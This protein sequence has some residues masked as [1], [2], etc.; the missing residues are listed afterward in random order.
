MEDE[1]GG[2]SD[3]T[4]LHRWVFR[5]RG[6]GDVKERDHMKDRCVDGKVIVKLILNTTR[7]SGFD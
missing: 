2:T 3:K 6:G 7:S 5:W 1:T 4:E